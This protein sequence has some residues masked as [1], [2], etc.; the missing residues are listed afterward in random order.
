MLTRPVFVG[1]NSRSGTTVIGRG[2]L[3]RHPE[4]ACTIPAESWFLTDTGGLCDMATA[5]APLRRR[6]RV[7]GNAT[8]R[9]GKKDPITY[10][11]SRM[12]GLWWSREWWQPGVQRGL[13]QS[14]TEG[15][16]AEALATFRVTRAH[17]PNSAARQLAADLIDP[18]TL[19]RGKARWV[20]T[21]P[22]NVRRAQGLH[23]VFPDMKLINMV[24]DGRDV[25]ASLVARAW[26]PDDYDVALRQWFRG[27]K[28]GHKGLR[29]LPP[30]TAITIDLSQLVVH[31]RDAQYQR[32]LDHLAIDDAPR[33]RKF[34]N[35][36]MTAGNANLG[37]WSSELSSRQAAKVNDTYA[38]MLA[39]LEKDNIQ[40][41]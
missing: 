11:E 9:H 10:F 15:Q 35:N 37:R 28:E 40:T 19:D 29:S 24:R 32:I 7:W 41:P 3:N 22:R 27:M 38:Q 18:S 1:G 17:N 31:D 21:T 36:Q 2:L 14:V 39:S 13:H 23:R 4:I 25:A 30:G 5:G 12:H 26:G 6:A 20:D 34:F 8:L 33:M 16:L